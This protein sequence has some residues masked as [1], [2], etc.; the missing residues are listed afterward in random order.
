[1]RLVLFGKAK[2]EQLSLEGIYL[3]SDEKYKGHPKW[4]SENG[5]RSIRYES[6][7]SWYVGGVS[8][9]G[10]KFK[11]TYL[12][13]LAGPKNDDSLP[14]YITKGWRYRGAQVLEVAAPNDVVF[15]TI[16]R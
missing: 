10:K 14:H 8:K 13:G 16:G 1:M 11:G 9:E 2:V 12:G 6:D 3:L 7:G 4:I 5:T 15:E